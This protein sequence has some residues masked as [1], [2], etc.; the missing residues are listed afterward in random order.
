MKT[1]FTAVSSQRGSNNQSTAILN[2]S[3]Q[4]KLRH[5][6][7]K[8]FTSLEQESQLTSIQGSKYQTI[9]NQCESIT[10]NKLMTSNEAGL[11]SAAMRKPE[12]LKQKDKDRDILIGSSFLKQNK[13][14][15]NQTQTD[16]GYSK[17]GMK[18]SKMP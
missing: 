6:N 9:I 15:K 18:P 2:S 7:I 4:P 8:A 13:R 16:F 12:S 11:R 5:R 3:N 17:L 14:L 1:Q 10:S